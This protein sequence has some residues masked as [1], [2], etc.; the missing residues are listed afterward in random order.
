MMKNLNHKHTIKK[1]HLSFIEFDDVIT[2]KLAND[3][4]Y[5][6]EGNSKGRELEFD[7]E[8]CLTCGYRL[9]DAEPILTQGILEQEF[10]RFVTCAKNNRYV[11]SEEITVQHT[12][13]EALERL[14]KNALAF[15]R[16][17]VNKIE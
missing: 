3:S 10:E 7:F 17:R 8:Y 13:F 2:A 14:I 9:L 5:F 4:R 12:D 11:S 15:G 1:T 6:G 16:I